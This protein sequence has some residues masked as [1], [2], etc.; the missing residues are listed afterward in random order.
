MIVITKKQLKRYIDHAVKKEVKK[1]MDIVP[2]EKSIELAR[3]YA[4]RLKEVAKNWEKK[5]PDFN[6]KSSEIYNEL[7]SGGRGSKFSPLSLINM[8][9][10]EKKM[11]LANDKIANNFFEQGNKNFAI[12][13]IEKIKHH[14]ANKN[15]YRHVTEI[16]IPK[17]Y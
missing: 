2:T 13:L 1:F 17:R 16:K 11:I 9:N 7:L 12:E 4:L 6:S 10:K 5:I 8:L 15:N 3:K 14:L